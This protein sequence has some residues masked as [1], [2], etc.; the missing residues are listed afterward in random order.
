MGKEAKMKPQILDDWHWFLTC[1]WMILFRP[2]EY[3]RIVREN[4]W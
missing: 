2:F 4:K 3:M 1:Y